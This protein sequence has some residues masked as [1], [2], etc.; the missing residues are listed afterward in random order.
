MI[1][2]KFL[3]C[4]VSGSCIF[5]SGF[6]FVFLIYICALICG[7]WIKWFREH[8]Q[9]LTYSYLPGKALPHFDS[10]FVHSHNLFVLLIKIFDT[11]SKFTVPV[12]LSV[13]SFF[14]SLSCLFIKMSLIWSSL[15]RKVVAS[16]HPKCQVK[17][18]CELVRKVMNTEP[19]YNLCKW[20]HTKSHILTVTFSFTPMNTFSKHVCVSRRKKMAECWK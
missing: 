2:Q 13:F 3:I 15:C 8:S 7:I 14:P 6:S 9:Q 5:F 17:C 4:F 10:Q 1:C 11:I 12:F 19:I 16:T 18:A 20:A